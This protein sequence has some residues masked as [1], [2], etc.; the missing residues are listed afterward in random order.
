MKIALLYLLLI[1]TLLSCNSKASENSLKEET[2][3]NIENV[4]IQ[5]KIDTIKVNAELPFGYSDLIKY[6]YP[7]FWKGDLENYG[8]LIKPDGK[9]FEQI[10][11]YFRKLHAIP[12]IGRRPEAIKIERIKLG[13]DNEYLDTIASKAIDNIKYRLPDIGK[14]K[15]Y[16]SYQ[17]SKGKFGEYGNL[18]IYDSITR[19]GRTLNVYNEVGGDQTVEFKFFTFDGKTIK[20]YNGACYDDGCDLKETYNVSIK[21]DGQIIVKEIK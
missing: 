7:K 12:T 2:K 9:E 15:F 19:N 8:Q 5:A 4:S 16:Y 10:G 13:N 11:E 14:Y 21:N 20:I 1:L 6:K 17:K 3:I 18:F